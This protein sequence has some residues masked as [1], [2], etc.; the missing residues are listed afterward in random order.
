MLNNPSLLLLA[1]ILLWTQNSHAM[2]VFARQYELSCAGCHSAFPRLNEF[3][4][5]FR[6][7]RGRSGQRG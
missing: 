4:E 5:R 2:P 1:G 3:G 6:D 7:S